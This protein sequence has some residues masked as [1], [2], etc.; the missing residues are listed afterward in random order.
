MKR[1]IGLILSGVFLLTSVTGCTPQKQRYHAQ[2]LMLF[3]TVTQI[4]GYADTKE[5]FSEFSTFIYNTLKEY[6]ELYDIYTDYEGINNIKTINDNAALAPVEVDQRIIDLLLYAKEMY[7]T[8]NGLC[9]VAMGSVLSIWHRYREE[10]VNDQENASLPAM[11]ELAAAS[12][13]TNINDLIINDEN[14]TVYFNDPKLKLDVGS[15]AKGYAV[16]QTVKAAVE[17]GYTSGLISVGG[18]VWA[19]GMKT[20]QSPWIVGIQDPFD[21]EALALTLPLTDA[22]MVTSGDYQRYYT[23]DDVR[24]AHIIH[25]VTLYPPRYFRSVT[26]ICEDSGMADALST[27]VFNMSYEDGVEYLKSMTGVSCV[28]IFNDG[29]IRYTLDLEQKI[30]SQK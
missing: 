17:A 13:H 26:I 8:T 15:I 14:N 19:I 21:M 2:F 5:S 1:M 6:H 10:G 23:V 4:V 29:E 18:N 7:Q 24:Y 16:Q 27:A 22:S 30:K 11:N 28:W 12:Q 25:P 3:N 9:N 20:E